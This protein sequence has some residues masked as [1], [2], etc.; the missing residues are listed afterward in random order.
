ML[1]TKVLGFLREVLAILKIGYGARLDS[2]LLGFS[3]PDLFY[4]L[5]IGG[6]IAAA[7][8]PTLSAAIER[9]EEEKAWKSVSVFFTL[10]AAVMLVVILLGGLFISP[11]NRLL[12]PD[13]S[14]M[15]LL[16]ADGVARIIFFQTF[17]FILI[18]QITAVLTAYKEFV[19]PNIG[20]AIYNIGCL[21]AIATLAGTAPGDLEATAYGIVASSLAYFLFLFYVAKPYMRHFRFSVDLREPGFLRLLRIAAP[22]IVAGTFNQ[23]NYIIQQRFTESLP[24]A[25]GSLSQAKQLYNLPFG[26][27]AAGIGSVVVANLSGFY[28]RRALREA[29]AFFTATLRMG[30]FLIVPCAMVYIAAGF[31]SVQAVFQWDPGSY[32]NGEVARTAELL[33]FFSLTMVALLASFFFSQVFYAMKKS[34]I[35]LITG[36]LTLLVNPLLCLILVRGLRLGLN[37]VAL[38]ALGYNLVNLLAM[39]LLLRRFE[40]G[41]LPKKMFG[42]C[43]QVGLGGLAAGLVLHGLNH[44]LMPPPGKLMQL[45][46]FAGKVLA[47]LLIYLAATAALNVAESRALFLKIS[48]RLKRGTRW[49]DAVEERRR[50]EREEG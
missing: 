20:N 7:I 25:V 8:T 5:L 30:L 34:Y 9:D 46:F 3:V 43:C 27:V 39:V 19:A 13:K 31:Q 28:A 6:A 45:L 16:G 24:G 50:D 38:A 47:A 37:G 14:P 29:R 35:A 48:G 4:E 10:S 12:F 17:F 11:L 44:I 23:V 26:I 18:G 33:G 36:G 21:I 42:F 41:L 40:P 15:V 2:Y 49:G 22:A 1:V 32:S